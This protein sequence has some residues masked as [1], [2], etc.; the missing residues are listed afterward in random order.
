MLKDRGWLIAVS[1]NC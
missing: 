1:E